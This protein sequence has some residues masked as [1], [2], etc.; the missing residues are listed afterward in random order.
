MAKT[1]EWPA[2]QKYGPENFKNPP[3]GNTAV[4]CQSPLK[5]VEL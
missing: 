2:R 1:Y 5:S 3:T 4:I